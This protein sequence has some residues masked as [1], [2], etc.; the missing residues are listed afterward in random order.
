MDKYGYGEKTFPRDVKFCPQT[1]NPPTAFVFSR[2][3]YGENLVWG[4]RP[5]KSARNISRTGTKFY[6]AGKSFLAVMVLINEKYCQMTEA[7][8][9]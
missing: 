5:K 6:I 8:K 4:S 3:S 1:G 2:F 7:A 9:H